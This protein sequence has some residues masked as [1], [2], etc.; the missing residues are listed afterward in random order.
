MSILDYLRRN[1]KPSAA[2]AKERLQII[3]AREHA[4]RGGPDFLPA[5]KR[6]ILEVVARYVP[7]DMEQVTVNLERDGDCEVLEL[8]VVLPEEPEPPR[9]RAR[10]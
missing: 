3:L 6:E 2:V 5:L 1:R 7:V 10:G 4:D 9:A 8:N